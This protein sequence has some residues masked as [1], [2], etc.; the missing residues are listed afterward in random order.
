MSATS[1]EPARYTPSDAAVVPRLH[2]LT[3]TRDGRDPLPCVAGALQA[4][5]TVGASI[6]V[7]VRHKSATDREL[8]QLTRRVVAMV[9]ETGPPRCWVVVDDR[10]DVALAAGAHGVHLGAHDLPVDVA[11]HLAAD[12]LRVGGTAR[13]PA[14]A[15]VLVDSGVAYLGVGPCF[16]TRTK[17]GLPAPLG[18]Q[19]L[20]EVA[21]AASVPVVA[22]GGVDAGRA[23]ALVRAGAHGV[24][25]VSA[26]SE[27]ADPQAATARLL[28]AVAVCP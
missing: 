2:V 17:R 6:A 20:G 14:G 21:R 7:Q 4:A 12:R 27:A 16:E 26:V 5:H 15:R 10:V 3:D 19:R 13:D 9:A 28:E 23:A 8:F 24:A 1:F 25:V 11:R 22:I 18:V